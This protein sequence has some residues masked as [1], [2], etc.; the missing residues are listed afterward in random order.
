MTVKRVS[1]GDS[2]IHVVNCLLY[3]LCLFM[4]VIHL[5]EIFTENTSSLEVRLSA[6]SDL[7][8]LVI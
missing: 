2:E 7:V 1:V 5:A 3:C 6:F 4:S 8:S